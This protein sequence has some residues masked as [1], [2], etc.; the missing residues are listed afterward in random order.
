M[1]PDALDHSI[2]EIRQQLGR[3]CDDSA[4]RIAAYDY[5]GRRLYSNPAF[6]ELI[7]Y[8]GAE[9]EGKHP[10]FPYW[11]DNVASLRTNLEELLSGEVERRGVRALAATFRH[12]SGADVPIL[13]TASA[14]WGREQALAYVLFV[15]PVDLGERV[16]QT[17][18]VGS[19]VDLADLEAFL[20]PIV[21]RKA[22]LD[23]SGLSPRQ[24]AVL[25]CLRTGSSSREIALELG[26][27]EHTARNHLKAIY[28]KLGIHSAKELIA[29]LGPTES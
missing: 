10:P 29:R 24:C 16:L 1:I 5:A 18:L 11:G 25:E 17:P 27:S 6:D 23:L 9:F 21:A 12:R 15:T 2:A 22:E 28:S 13:M 4:V 3:L 7:G 19:K 26:I 14:V 8:D 20:A